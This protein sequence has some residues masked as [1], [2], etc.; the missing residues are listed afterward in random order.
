MKKIC[1]FILAVFMLFNLAG[2]KNNT[3]SNNSSNQ[4]KY[5]YSGTV[6]QVTQYGTVEGL[7]DNTTN[8]LQWL[9][10]PYAKPPVG[11]LRWK[12]PQ[13][14]EKWNNTLE[15]KQYKN[16]AVQLSGKEVIGSEDCLYLNIWRPN[17][18]DENIPVMVFVHG[19]GNITGSGESFKGDVLA[20]KSNSII[21]SINYRLGPMGWFLNDALKDGDKLNDSGNYGLLDIFKALEWVQNNIASFGGNPKNVTLSGQSAGARDVLAS[22]ISPYSKGLYQKAIPLSGGLTLAE[23]EE[24]KKF[25]QEIIKKLVIKD[26]KASNDEEAQKWIESQSSKD[27]AAYLRG[28]DAKEIVPLYGTVAIKMG[29]FPHLYKDGNVIPKE[30]FELL[31]TGNYN[32]V[33]IIIGSMANE[34]AGFAAMDPY[35]EGAV[36]NGK[37][38][39]DPEKLKILNDAVTYGSK[40]YAGFNADKVADLLIVNKDQP[41][42]Y[43]YRCAWGTQEGV[44]TNNTKLFAAAHGV[45]VDLITANYAFGNYFKGFYTEENK[46][47]RTELSNM[48]MTYIKNFLHTGD[49]NGDNLPKWTKWQT[50]ADSDKILRLDADTTK[51]TAVMSKEHLVKEEIIK[52]MNDNLPKN[53]KDIIIE[54]LLKGRFFWEY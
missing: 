16:K 54:K 36:L 41:S 28:K 37:I 33:P 11:E 19:G 18:K 45:D 8:T 53:E 7:L 22:L 3:P 9:G 35:F 39:S 46:P 29:Q 49:P 14:P 47:G 20:Q 48:M 31:K 4:E 21:I 1:L 30:G 5:K 34:F 40:M 27:L 44:I 25:T 50:A 12:A 15:T 17:T 2:C 6:L 13:N 23:P 42:V 26:G 38:Y 51:A 43:A 52:E 24:G 10:V 32:K